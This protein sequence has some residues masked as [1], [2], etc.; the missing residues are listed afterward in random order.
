MSPTNT[1][2]LNTKKRVIF[3]SEAGK[4]FSRTAKG[5]ATYNPKAKYHKS[6]G[7][8]ERATKYVKNLLSI[9]SPIRPKFDR[10]ER[11]NVGAKRAPYAARKGGMV[12]RLKRKGYLEQ[13]F[14]P[15][16]K[17][18]VGRPRKAVSWNLPNPLGEGL[19]KKRSNAGKKRG[20]RG[21]GLYKVKFAG[22]YVPRG[23]VL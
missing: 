19:R 5:T 23:A 15:K 21:K 13:L 12:V 10:K 1:G 11:A 2:F 16:A 8:T 20:P 3:R 7:G 22:S 14:S 4:Y 6:P 17:R 18:P 9:P